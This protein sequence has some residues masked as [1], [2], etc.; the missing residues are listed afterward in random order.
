MEI[1]LPKIK[2][3]REKLEN[4]RVLIRQ[5]LANVE[6]NRMKIRKELLD[7]KL[8]ISHS[9]KLAIQSIK[10]RI[11]EQA[12]GIEEEET[13]LKDKCDYYRRKEDK[14]RIIK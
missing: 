7:A 13:K 12:R 3:K 6:R 4:D 9:R 10:D 14:L 11:D 8:D 5:L 2:S 1:K